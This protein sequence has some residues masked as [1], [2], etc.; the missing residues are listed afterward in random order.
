M[1]T[2]GSGVYAAPPVGC[3]T[4]GVQSTG[5]GWVGLISVEISHDQ[6]DR[7]QGLSPAVSNAAYNSMQTNLDT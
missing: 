4:A 6:A 5:M 7:D 2:I 3:H 1:Q